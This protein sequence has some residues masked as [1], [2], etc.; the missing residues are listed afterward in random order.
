MKYVSR[1]FSG[2]IFTAILSIYFHAYAEL[3]P[4]QDFTLKVDSLYTDIILDS[5]KSD[6]SYITLRETEVTDEMLSA[7]LKGE[8]AYSFRIFQHSADEP[9]IPY[10]DITPTTVDVVTIDNIGG[11]PEYIGTDYRLYYVSENELVPIEIIDSSV[12]HF[13]FTIEKLGEYVLYF[14]Q[15]DFKV[16]FY[17]DTDSTQVYEEHSGLSLHERVSA[18][19][20]PRRDGYVFTGWLTSSFKKFCYDTFAPGFGGNYYASW[21]SADEGYTPVKVSLI[22]NKLNKIGDNKIVVRAENSNGFFINEVYEW[23]FWLS[24]EN[25]P[26]RITDAQYNDAET[27]ILTLSGDLPEQFDYKIMFTESLIDYNGKIDDRNLPINENG[28][29]KGT[30]VSN[31]SITSDGYTEEDLSIL[32]NRNK[33]FFTIDSKE[34]IVFGNKK[35]MD[36]SPK[37]VNDLT[38]LPA[39]YVA[40]ALGAAVEW[41]DGTVTITKDENVIEIYIGKETA[42]V[43]GEEITLLSPAFIENDRTYCPVRFICESLGAD[44][45]WDGENRVVTVTKK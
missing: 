41:N 22:Y 2:I 35:T 45:D 31:N 44:V 1:L 39:R 19:K 24:D 21:R 28:C 25:A 15:N 33:V 26:V 5:Q 7:A 14:K 8:R 4:E 16:T 12:F 23:S 40:E 32:L 6:N 36:V 9:V 30:L 37:I 38:M 17:W 29:L 27:V 18:P 3:L 11:P 20:V 10:P 34:Y 13:T 43:N 42:T